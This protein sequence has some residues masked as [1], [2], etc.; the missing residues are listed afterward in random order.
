[1]SKQKQ[2]NVAKTFRLSDN[3]NALLSMMSSELGLS[4]TGV[5]ELAIREK[6][7]AM[8]VALPPK[9]HTANEPT[10][11]KPDQTARK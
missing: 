8:N 9:Q 11:P 1:M 5:L 4:L 2:K 6:A 7:A 3:A 10:P